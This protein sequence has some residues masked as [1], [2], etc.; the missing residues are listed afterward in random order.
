MREA[1]DGARLVAEALDVLAVLAE[2]VVQDLE[3]DVALE[4]AVVRPIDARHPARANDFLELV[5]FSDQLADH[6]L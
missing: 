5:P 1:S 2:L 3:R 4:Q 6:N